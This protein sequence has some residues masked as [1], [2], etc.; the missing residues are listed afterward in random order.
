MR[1]RVKINKKPGD[2][3]SARHVCEWNKRESRRWESA[4]H[5]GGEKEETGRDEIFYSVSY[6]VSGLCPEN[7]ALN[8]DETH[9][10][11][12][13]VFI[14]VGAQAMKWFCPNQGSRVASACRITQEVYGK[15]VARRSIKWGVKMWNSS[16]SQWVHDK[17]NVSFSIQ[18]N[19]R[20]HFRK[21]NA[22]RMAPHPTGWRRNVF[23]CYF[24]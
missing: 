23:I 17:I 10:Q 21:A 19:I 12:I 8:A 14:G 5:G 18:A 6:G 22:N 2:G 20:W 16:L 7:N 15:Y 11:I 9:L 13:T 3:E 24:V 1:L 4:R